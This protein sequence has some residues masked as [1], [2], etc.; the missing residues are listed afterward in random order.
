MQRARYDNAMDFALRAQS[1][2]H[3]I[4]NTDNKLSNMIAA[5]LLLEC[6]IR[7][8]GE[9]YVQQVLDADPEM[10]TTIAEIQKESKA[11]LTKLNSIP[12]DSPDNIIF[13]NFQK[14]TPPPE[15]NENPNDQ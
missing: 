10:K 6:A 9:D 15:S 14:E 11:N 13:V 5:Y 7:A 1:F 8:L 12:P 4:A 3:R 2:F